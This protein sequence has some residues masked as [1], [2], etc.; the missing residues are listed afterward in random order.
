MVFSRI[1]RKVLV[2]KKCLNTAGKGTSSQ[3]RMH[4]FKNFPHVLPPDPIISIFLVLSQFEHA[5]GYRDPCCLLPLLKQSHQNDLRSLYHNVHE[6]QNIT[7]KGVSL[8]F[9]ASEGRGH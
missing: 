6:M 8:I 5:A 7:K 4:I 1:G 3:S 2:S 9:R